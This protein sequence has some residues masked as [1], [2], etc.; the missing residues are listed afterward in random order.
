MAFQQRK[1]RDIRI[2]SLLAQHYGQELVE[3]LKS[4]FVGL[5]SYNN[6]IWDLGYIF[7]Y[8]LTRK[9]LFFGIQIC[10]HLLTQQWKLSLGLPFTTAS[11]H[12]IIG[13]TVRF[14]VTFLISPII[15]NFSA[16]NLAIVSSFCLIM[17]YTT[18]FMWNFLQLPVDL[19]I[20]AQIMFG[21]F[22][23]TGSGI[24]YATVNIVTQ[25]WLD[26]KRAKL[27]PYIMA[28]SPIFALSG[29]ILFT[30]MC[31]LYTWSGAVLVLIGLMLNCIVVVL[32]FT[33][34]PEYKPE[35]KKSTVGELLKSEVVKHPLFQKIIAF[36]LC[37]TGFIMIPFFT[38]TINIATEYG[39]TEEQVRNMMIIGTTFD[40]AF[41][42]VMSKLAERFRVTQLAIGWSLL[43]F[44]QNIV[45][46]YARDV[47]GFYILEALIGA[48]LA[49]T[50]MKFVLIMECLG[51]ENLPDYFAIEQAITIPISLAIPYGL[52]YLGNMI[53]NPSIIYLLCVV[54]SFVNLLLA[55]A[56][57]RSIR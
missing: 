13:G 33:E 18:V 42:P 15:H 32:L 44:V 30:V 46:Y 23:G 3:A 7:R 37:Q 8:I 50:G 49:A 25:Q 45:G 31:D 57:D 27:N 41:R 20:I 55:L 48:S 47:I 56:L 12:Q 11:T 54:G 24:G 39:L 2:L 26:K 6:L 53:G 22:N 29:T 28:G 51:T 14:A 52:A 38:Q 43:F 36:N 40:I 34:H 5:F 16:T 35:K 4:A 19:F 9:G 21:V 1:T 17:S 10:Q